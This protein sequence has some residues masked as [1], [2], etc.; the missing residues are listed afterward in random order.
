[1]TKRKSGLIVLLGNENSPSGELSEDAKSR[2][3]LA[4]S[5]A[6]KNPNLK[7]LPTGGFGAYFNASD[8]AH[9]LLLTQ[10]LVSRGLSPDRIL[11]YV[12]SAGTHEDALMSRR[13]AVDS[14]ATEVLVVTSAF[15]TGRA[16]Y[17]FRRALF[18]FDTQFFSDD[19]EQPAALDALEKYKIEREKATW[20][21]PPLYGRSSPSPTDFPS[22]IYNNANNEQKHYD[23]IS[24]LMV[25]GQFVVFGFAY[26][27]STWRTPMYM[28]P[29]HIVVGLLILALFL[30]YLRTAAFANTSRD[31][32]RAIELQWSPGFSL[33]AR[34]RNY[35]RPLPSWIERLSLPPSA[36][37]WLLRLSRV[38]NFVLTL[39]F[40]T[41][42]AIVTTLM[43]LVQSAAFILALNGRLMPLPLDNYDLSRGHF[44]RPSASKDSEDVR[45]T[46][47]PDPL[48]VPPGPRR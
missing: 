17:L 4:L 30:M 32:M 19:R 34:R 48:G 13:I 45:R 44:E 35:S 7:I 24:Y 9:G 42:V 5:L 40:T 1:M 22:D 27:N 46:L 43:I 26:T 37:T 38:T 39:G 10:Y 47:P 14:N 12:N 2:A 6:S 33:N 8:V 25:A 20:I 36:H 3:H 11:P 18:D 15:H 23:R 16:R 41:T 31:L 28:A 29:A 21:D